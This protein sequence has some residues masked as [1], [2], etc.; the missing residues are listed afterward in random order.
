[1]CA[2]PT[3][4]SRLGPWYEETRK[5]S[6]TARPVRAPSIH[7]TGL[8]KTRNGKVVLLDDVEVYYIEYTVY[9]P[10]SPS[11]DP[12][13]YDAEK[14][15]WIFDE[16]STYVIRL[17]L[18][19]SKAEFDFINGSGRALSAGYGFPG[20]GLQP[21][22]VEQVLGDGCSDGV[23]GPVP[24]TKTTTPCDPNAG[25]SSSSGSTTVPMSYSE[26]TSF[27]PLEVAL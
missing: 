9:E 4:R 27:S 26:I 15:E 25:G 13:F 16:G 23:C 12:A 5:F 21:G 1:V 14:D 19:A 3:R 11:C 22:A 20:S 17:R 6:K 18:T 10:A 7:V 8:A 24:G 2:Q